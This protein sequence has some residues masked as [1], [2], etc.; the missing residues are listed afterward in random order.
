[1]FN[2]RW[3][4]NLSYEKFPISTLNFFSGGGRGAYCRRRKRRDYVDASLRNNDY[5][6][7][8][9]YLCLAQLMLSQEAISRKWR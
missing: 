5:E 4:K 6:K 3:F 7:R 1:M 8:N 9:H 2:Y